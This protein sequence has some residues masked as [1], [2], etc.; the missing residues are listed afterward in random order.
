M[1]ID[2][3][4]MKHFPGLSLEPPLFYNWNIGIRFELGDPHEEDEK[5]YMERVLK[6]GLTLLKAL[7]QNH[8]E[9]FIVCYYDKL[10]R[11]PYKKVNAFNRS[12]RNKHVKY[13]MHHQVFP[14]REP[15]EDE[16]DEYETHRLL[17]K[18]EVQDVNLPKMIRRFFYRNDMPRLYF[19][20]I[21]RGTIFSIY[22]DRGCDLVS[23][24]KENIEEIYYTFNEWILD[25]DRSR[26]DGLFQ[27]NLS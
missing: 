27:N 13:Q 8:D 2:E 23:T 22:D 26:I 9:L 14:F 11:E 18:C 16:D 10:K 3:Y 4:M 1:N 19:V 7:H 21:K 6:R 20:N 24:K 17:L 5:K 15:E 12:M 25:W